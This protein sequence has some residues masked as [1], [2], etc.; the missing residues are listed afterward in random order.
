MKTTT[1]PFPTN[2]TPVPVA[3]ITEVV[4]K[5]AR[6]PRPKVVKRKFIELADYVHRQFINGNNTGS[7]SAISINLNNREYQLSINDCQRMITL[8]GWLGDVDHLKSA[9]DRIDV[10]LNVIGGFREHLIQALKQ[11]TK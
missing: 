5:R 2:E 9:I 1:K 10:M 7:A 11:N 3:P 6:K 8:H 4:K